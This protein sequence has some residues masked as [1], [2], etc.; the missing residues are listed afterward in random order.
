MHPPEE[1][2]EKELPPAEV[3]MM[4]KVIRS[5]L[6]QSS[7]EVE[8]IGRDPNSPL[9]SVKSFEQ[10]Q[11]SQ[12][13]LR[14]VYGMGFNAPSKIQESTLPV[15]LAY[16]P[17]NLIAQ[18]QNGT[19]KTAA[20]LLASLSRVRV[21]ERYPQVLI[22][23]PTF[24]LAMQTLEVAQRMAQYCVGIEFRSAVKGEMLPKSYAIQEHIIIGTPGKVFDWGMRGHFNF[25]ALSIFILDEADIMISIQG[26]HDQCLR[27]HKL[28]SDSCQCIL[29]SA[30]YSA[31]VMEF[32]EMIIFNPIIMQLKRE[33]ESLDNV[34]Q[35]Y[36]ECNSADQKY[37]ALSNIY[38]AMSIGQAIIF[39]R[40]K[41]TTFWLGTKMTADGHSV[42]YLS[43]D[44]S[45]ED[46]L[47]VL[48]RFR[49]GKEK[50]LITTN[51]CSRGID[52]EQVTIVVNFDLPVTVNGAADCETYLHRIGRTG[53]FGKKGIAIN[54]V[55][56]E[57]DRDILITI[58][59]H[60]GRKIEL[61]DAFDVDALE[62]MT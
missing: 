14:G 4:R 59:E 6:L 2:D 5:H 23:S 7:Q 28:V 18:S 13:L 22:L 42:G 16:P 8:V 12:S 44:L 21:E 20:F 50:V 56:K 15:L 30:T 33:E 31:E 36:I 57:S 3:S 19:G 54:M 48:T 43:S 34:K 25:K 17:V 1:T 49:E 11:L 52:I 61:I 62:K 37:A 38:G 45:M 9:H 53:R 60:F 39:C 41:K 29:F 26:H 32:A 58:E 47:T 55:E 35:Y 51:V 27:I 46:R 24:E 40:T 10:L